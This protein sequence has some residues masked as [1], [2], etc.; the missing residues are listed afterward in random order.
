MEKEI[1]SKINDLR[2]LIENIIKNFD[3]FLYNKNY[4]LN[5]LNQIEDFIKQN[6]K[7]FKVSI[8]DL[9]KTSIKQEIKKPEEKNNNNQNKNL[10]EIK[11]KKTVLNNN[12]INDI[13]NNSNITYDN[14]F[15]SPIDYRI[16]YYK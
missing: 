2:N 1:F 13:N 14:E 11:L 3:E 9:E 10:F 8:N 15:N 4:I 7:S 12:N 16:K 5:S 6:Y